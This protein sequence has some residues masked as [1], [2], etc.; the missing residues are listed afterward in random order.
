MKTR[1]RLPSS[2]RCWASSARSRCSARSRARPTPTPP[3][4]R[5]VGARRTGQKLPYVPWYW[6]MVVSPSD[7]NMLV[8][9]DEQG[10]LPLDRTAARRG[11]RSGPKGIHATSLAQ[12][13]DSLV[14]GGVARDASPNPVARRD[15]PHGARRPGR[16]RGRAPTTGKTWK[17]AQ[18]ARPARHARSS[19]SRR[20]RRTARRSTRC[21]T[22]ASSTARPTGR[23]RSSS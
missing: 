4:P 12:S 5:P 17:D 22:T 10:P 20:I 14:A 7:P 16:A 18:A 6:T 11:R 13:D 8:L 23:P 1:S 21:S 3:R 9:G 15:R 19:R 2:H